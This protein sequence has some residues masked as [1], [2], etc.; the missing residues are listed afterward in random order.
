MPLCRKGHRET[1][2]GKLLLVGNDHAYLNI[3]HLDAMDNIQKILRRHLLLHSNGKKGKLRYL[4]QQKNSQKKKKNFF[5]SHTAIA[6]K[7]YKNTFSS[8]S[9][10]IAK[11]EDT[12]PTEAWPLKKKN[13]KFSS[14]STTRKKSPK[15][16]VNKAHL[17]QQ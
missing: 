9:T 13:K 4:L 15:E 1:A 7:W 14:S 6:E 11:K 2:I 3:R 16:P 12:S 8:I 5:T 17:L 10:A